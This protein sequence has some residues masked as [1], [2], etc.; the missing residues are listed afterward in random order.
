[1]SSWYKISLTPSQVDAWGQHRIM[2]AF[3]RYCLLSLDASDMALFASPSTPEGLT[4][5]LSPACYPD[6]RDF[7]Y[8]HTR[9]AVSPC[10]KP[11]EPVLLLADDQLAGP[12]DAWEH[13]GLVHA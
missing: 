13:F 4:L 7:I 11:T 6:C 3:L 10:E 8:L 2:E 12:Q 5:Y 9:Y 1:M